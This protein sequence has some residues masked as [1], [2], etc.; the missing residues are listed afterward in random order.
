MQRKEI[1]FS[2]IKELDANCSLNITEPLKLDSL[3]IIDLIVAMEERFNTLFDVM[4]LDIE[5]F[6]TISS[7][8]ELLRLKL[9]EEH[10]EN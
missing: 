1:L 3:A 2:I 4:E 9:G 8:L 7:I 5:N 6:N 10:G